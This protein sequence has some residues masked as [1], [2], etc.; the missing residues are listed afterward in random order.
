MP[1]DPDGTL[2]AI[3]SPARIEHSNADARIYGLT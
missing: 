3:E 1:F 2:P